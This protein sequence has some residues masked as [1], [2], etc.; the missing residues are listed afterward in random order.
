MYIHTYICSSSQHIMH[1][2]HTYIHT[3]IRSHNISCTFY[4]HA[5]IHTYI[6]MQVVAAYHAHSMPFSLQFHGF[7]GNDKR[8][9]LASRPVTSEEIGADWSNL[10]EG[11][12][13]F[14]LDHRMPEVCVVYVCMYVCIYVTSL[15]NNCELLHTHI[16]TCIHTYIQTCI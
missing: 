11:I 9:S 4:M 12:R 2:T 8:D 7:G 6:H 13:L 1:I 5:Y 15:T 16:H 3:C 14:P 10:F